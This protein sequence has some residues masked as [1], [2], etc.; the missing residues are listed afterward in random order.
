MK[1]TAGSVAWEGVIEQLEKVLRDW[2]PEEESSELKYRNSLAK[3]LRECAP[4][5]GVETEYR[6][7]GTTVDIYF[8]WKG[9]IFD[10]HILFELK[11]NLKDKS[12]YDR[13]VGQIEGLKPRQN[14][15]F[16]VLCGET[17]PELLN[18]LRDKYKEWLSGGTLLDSGK[19]RIIEKKSAKAAGSS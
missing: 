18:R 2:T 12:A 11:R 9:L 3:H 13:L 10:D 14:T 7:A 8:R 4:D 1:M 19:M 6:H 15:I 17:K 5:A 16:L